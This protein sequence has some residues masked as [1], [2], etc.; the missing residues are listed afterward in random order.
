[1]SGD[2]LFFRRFAEYDRRQLRINRSSPNE[3]YPDT[4]FHAEQEVEKILKQKLQDLGAE[5]DATHNLASLASDVAMLCGTD[6]SEPQHEDVRTAC[7]NL[8]EVYSCCRYP[9]KG[10]AVIR[11]DA[12]KAAKAVNDLEVIKQWSRTQYV[13]DSFYSTPQYSERMDDLEEKRSRQAYR[14][15]KKGA[16]KWAKEN[17][18][19]LRKIQ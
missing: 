16:K 2:K 11:F 3:V 4:C 9:L 10:E 5:N 13:P 17:G 12:K 18:F 15:G 6:I 8:T 19:I 1:M 7:K 14:W